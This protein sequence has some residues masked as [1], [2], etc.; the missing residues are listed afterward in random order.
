MILVQLIPHKI[1]ARLKKQNVIFLIFDDENEA[2]VKKHALTFI[3]QAS[4]YFI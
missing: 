3:L 2:K 4:F 1:G